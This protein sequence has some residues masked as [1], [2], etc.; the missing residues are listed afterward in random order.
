[1]IACIC[2][3][4]DTLIPTILTKTKTVNSWLFERGFTPD[5]IRV[6]STENSFVTANI[7]EIWLND[8]FLPAVEEKRRKLRTKLGEFDDRAVLLLDGCS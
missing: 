6:L 3:D 8:V 2:L 7:F 1:M 4:G 5:N